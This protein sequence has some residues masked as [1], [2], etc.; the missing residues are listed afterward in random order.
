MNKM[1]FS[2][3]RKL[4]TALKK[5]N[6]K[7]TIDQNKALISPAAI[8][9][10]VTIGVALLAAGV[11]ALCYICEPVI[12]TLLP[13]ENITQSLLLIMLILSVMLS[14]KNIVTVLYTADDL[15]VL[16]PLPFTAGQIVSA[17]LAVASSFPVNIS[18]ISVN[19]V[20]LGL[21]IRAGM[22][23]GFMI[24]VI[25]SSI[26]VP[27]TG[28]SLGLLLTV[29]I[30]RLF[31]FIR[32]RDITV[33]LG[34]IFTVILFVA[35]VFAINRFNDEGSSQV[36]A[37]ALSALA[38]A[39]S[40][41]PNISFMSDFMFSSSVV[42]LFV[43]LAVTFAVAALALLA[44][45]LF[46]LSTALSMQSTGTGRRA[47]TKSAL[48]GSRKTNALKALTRYETKSTVRNPAFLIYGFV[49]TFIWPVLIILPVFLGKDSFLDKIVFPLDT[50][51][52]VVAAVL[53]S[54]IASCFACGFNVL[55]STAF[56]REGDTY[57]VLRAMPIAFSD[58][59]NS[60]RNFSLLIC[61]IGSVVY[62]LILGV[63]CAV[64]NIISLSDLWVVPFALVI[65]F[66]V[67]LILVDLM[68]LKNAKKPLFN[69]DTDT[70]ISR[71]LCW[72]NYIALIVGFVAYVGFMI[73][74]IV[75]S[76][77]RENGSSPDYAAGIWILVG[78]AVAATAII[79]AAIAVNRTS[80]KL[81]EKNLKALD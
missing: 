11:F 57:S 6:G 9:V 10:L 42:G 23:A 15:P 81:A 43:S 4:I 80:V 50:T 24:G 32:N 47:V 75:S 5:C 19:A 33:L 29:I 31:G 76:V 74:M 71:K 18:L 63:A 13:I 61:S 78:S 25:L 35:Y 45:K 30:F 26:L 16:L 56:S 38:S 37:Q 2:K 69:R 55:P 65:S 53:I 20:C 12:R 51:T 72:V 49:M 1:G 39:A 68:L 48:Q 7:A 77:V 44:V 64:L 52:A 21:G 67:N 36:A 66:M 59:F 60:K 79:I 34:G 58:Y 54:V 28:I 3:I 40:F 46:Y 62:I 22:G 27:I 70:E 14:I 73:V 17:K 41:F 8:K